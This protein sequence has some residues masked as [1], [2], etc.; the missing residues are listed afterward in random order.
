[1][2]APDRLL[3]LW[4]TGKCNLRCRYCYAAH[5]P[6]ADMR[7]ETARKAMDYMDGHPFRLQLAGGEPLLNKPLL[8]RIL[9]DV[10]DDP[11]I[12]CSIQTNATLIDDGIAEVF[13]KYRVAVG[14]SLDGKPEINEKQRGE[15]PKALEGIRILGAHGIRVNLT[16]VVT[17]E[18][19]ARLHELVD[20]A[21]YLGNVN[22]IG[23][24]LL[25]RAGRAVD[26][27]ISPA[28]P[29]A[30]EHG[31][32]ALKKRVDEVNRLLPRPLIVREFEKAKYYL[33]AEHPCLDYCFAAR[34]KSFVVLPDG[35]CWPCGS[36]AGQPEYSMG[37][38]HSAVQ[39]LTIQCARPEQCETCVYRKA[40]TGGCPSRGLLRGGFDELDCLMKKISFELVQTGGR[41]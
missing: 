2:S 31:L 23:L 35:G 37:N 21:L 5:G 26:N 14:V 10:G 3:A 12:P 11:S 22:G 6:Q 27:G 16:V 33:S 7:Y 9:E 20:M 24:D 25:R 34:G 18:N 30:L 15:T 36:L 17:A 4:L 40:C 39:P 19:A 41:S 32:R 29:E 38:V 8:L 13:R 1:M 28:A